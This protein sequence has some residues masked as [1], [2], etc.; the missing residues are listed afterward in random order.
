[1]FETLWWFSTFTIIIFILYSY[2]VLKKGIIDKRKSEKDNEDAR[3]KRSCLDYLKEVKKPEILTEILS[4]FVSYF[5][6]LIFLFIIYRSWDWYE[7]GLLTCFIWIID[8]LKKVYSSIREYEK[9]IGSKWRGILDIL[10]LVAIGLVFTIAAIIDIVFHDVKDMTKHV[11]INGD[12]V[13]SWEKKYESWTWI[14]KRVN[15][16]SCE[17]SLDPNMS[18]YI[19]HKNCP[20]EQA[21]FSKLKIKKENH[22]TLNTETKEILKELKIIKQDIKNTKEWIYNLLNKVKNTK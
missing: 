15:K 6:F 13:Y 9:K 1:M 11:N 22:K 3:N 10:I 12:V 19:F 14:Y 21:N 4:F 16:I 17:G 5:P 2:S 18:W 20:L 7:I 8:V